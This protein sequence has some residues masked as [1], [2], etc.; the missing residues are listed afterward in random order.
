MVGAWYTSL[1]M[2]NLFRKLL[3]LTQFDVFFWPLA[4]S[5]SLGCLIAASQNILA[6][7]SNSLGILCVVMAAFAFGTI[8]DAPL[9]ALAEGRNPDNPV[10]NGHLS[11]PD[12]WRL[13]IFLAAMGLIFSSI[14]SRSTFLANLGVLI[15]GGFYF[16]HASRLRQSLILDALG[17]SILTSFLPFLSTANLS[18]VQFGSNSLVTG[19]LAFF[20]AYTSYF[21]LVQS[22]EK[23][24][25]D[26]NTRPKV[27][28]VILLASVPIVI[29]TLF[30]FTFSRL[31]PTWVSV[32]MLVLFLIMLY[33]QFT[34]CTS[35]QGE[36]YLHAIFAIYQRA[37]VIALATFFLATQ[38]FNNI[39]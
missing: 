31:V 21:S 26:G 37:L 3:R 24:M 5:I 23:R 8:E 27:S 19:S 28:G 12:A 39:R 32:L 13:S 16:H 25:A 1:T 35:I 11:I 10:S 22:Q 6:Q 38:L 18:S 4:S 36:T 29:A 17:F 20:L 2:K 15:V 14:T 7:I 9:D 33:P 34:R 30:I